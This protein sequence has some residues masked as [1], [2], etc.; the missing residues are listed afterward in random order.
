[1]VGGGR[2]AALVTLTVSGGG[3]DSSCPIR[4][5]S[6]HYPR[7]TRALSGAHSPLAL[8]LSLPRS[9]SPSPSL[10]LLGAAFGRGEG[11]VGRCKALGVSGLKKRWKKTKK[12]LAGNQFTMLS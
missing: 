1:M 11:E 12:N 3:G 5:V 9:L 6:A 4:A 8:S 7:S 2:R 10:S